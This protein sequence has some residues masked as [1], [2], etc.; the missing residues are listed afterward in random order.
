MKDFLTIFSP[1][2]VI[3]KSTVVLLVSVQAIAFCLLWIFSPFVFLPSQSETFSAAMQLWSAGLG[4]ELLT[5]FTLNVEA[6]T[7]A[8]GIS[9]L[10]AYSTVL[11]FFRPIVTLISKLRFL[12]LVGLTFFFT[13]MAANGHRLKLDLLAFSVSVF[14]ITGMMDV[15]D[16]I[17]KVHFDLARTLRMGEWRLVWEVVVLG[18]IDKVFD[19]MRQNAAISW[20]MLTMVEGMARSDGGIGTVLLTQNKHFHLS[21]VLAIQISILIVGLCQDYG[22]GMLRN[23]F[24]PYAKLTVERK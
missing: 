21:S 2:R 5:S 24:C 22:I 7:L 13:L 8:T 3:S 17:P 10:L 15:L 19:V 18:Q 4:T 16:S 11:P 20:M 9:L 23:L 6:I 14:F 1:N 12:S